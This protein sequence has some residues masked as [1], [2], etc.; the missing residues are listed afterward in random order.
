MDNINKRKFQDIQK[1]RQAVYV[2]STKRTAA[3]DDSRVNG[4]EDTEAAPGAAG[5]KK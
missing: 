1:D 5:T 3:V 2:G 4:P